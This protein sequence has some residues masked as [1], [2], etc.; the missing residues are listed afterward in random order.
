[1]LLLRALSIAKMKMMSIK[2]AKLITLSSIKKG[3]GLTVLAFFVGGCDFSP[4][5]HKKIIVAQEYVM[6][7]RY[8]DAIKEYND[9]LAQN[10]PSEIQV[11]IH[12]QLGGIHSTNLGENK[13]AV[14]HFSKVADHT[15]DP[16]WLVKSE[17]RMGE[18]HFSFLRDYARALENYKMLFYFTP[19]LAKRDFY[20]YRLALCYNKLG[21][22]DEAQ[23]IFLNIKKRPQHEYYISSIFELGSLHFLKEEWQKAVDYWS[24]YIKKEKRRDNIVQAKFLMANAYETMEDLQKAYNIY[25]S[26][27]GEYPNTQVIQN[28][29]RSIYERRIARKR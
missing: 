13:L 28:R 18:I 29:L 7:Q 14:G 20:E 16:L 3:L 23:K 19:K 9:I 21:L 22:E 15:Q 24:E 17:E 6:A 27:L 4:R 10:P 1:M 25:Y 2:R 8:R 5:I 11:K 12:Y 26:I